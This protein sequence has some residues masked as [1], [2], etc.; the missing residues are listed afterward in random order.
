MPL[1]ELPVENNK[2][3]NFEWRGVV[4]FLCEVT[5]FEYNV[6]TSLSPI[7]VPFS[8]TVVINIV[9]VEYFTHLFYFSFFLSPPYYFFHQE[10]ELFPCILS[11]CWAAYYFLFF[12]CLFLCFNEFVKLSHHRSSSSN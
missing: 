10:V 5:L 3:P 1:F 4:S 2:H 12:L 8:V 9:K 6:S 7:V 11:R